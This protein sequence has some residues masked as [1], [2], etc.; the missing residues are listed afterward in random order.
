[1]SDSLR[2]RTRRRLLSIGLALVCLGALLGPAAA[3]GTTRSCGGVKTAGAWTSIDTPTTVNAFAVE[4]SDRARLFVSDG[5]TVY[6][7]VDSGCSWRP[8]FTLPAIPTIEIPFTNERIVAISAPSASLVYLAVTGPHVVVSR[9]GGRTWAA[10]DSGLAL[11]GDPVE[12]IAPAP[13]AVYLLVQ[14]TASD[15]ILDNPFTG[16][17]TGA[18][19]AASVLY[20]SGD[21]GRT[22][23]PSARPS[24]SAQG[25]RGT[26]ASWSEGIGKVWDI[27]VA[28]G[29]PE[30]LWAATVAGV[31]TSADRGAT[32]T[33]A[34]P[35]TGAL[36][37]LDVRAVDAPAAGSVEVVAVDPLAGTV[38]ST[39]SATGAGAWTATSWPG[40]RTNF[41]QV[42]QYK[43]V[44]L[45]HTDG[46]A[47][48]GSGAKGVFALTPPTAWTDVSPLALGSTAGILVDLTPGPDET[49][50]GRA[51]GL[52]ATLLRYSV[53]SARRTTPDDDRSPLAG[54]L[55][56]LAQPSQSIGAL[57]PPRRARLEPGDAIVRLAPGESVTKSYSLALPP[58]PSPVD[59][60]F[61]LDT[62]SS[63]RDVIRALA[64]SVASIATRLR[65]DGVD[66][67]TG[68]GEFRT[69]PYP[70]EAAYNF[71]YRRDVAL[72]PPG[73]ELARALLEIE[74]EGQSGSNLTGL[75]QAATGAGQDV[76]P[77]GRSEGDIAPGQDA[78]FRPHA[79]RVVVHAAD[80]AFA[81]PERGDGVNGKYP[82]PTWPGPGFDEAIAALT[83]NH[84]HQV[85]AAIGY[86]SGARPTDKLDNAWTDLE[87]VAA[88][89][90]TSAPRDGVDCDGDGRIDLR[91][92]RPLVC[93]IPAGHAELLAPAIVGLVEG[94]RDV[95]PVRL[96]APGGAGVVDSIVPAEYPAV[97]LRTR[98]A[99]S[100]DVTYSCPHVYERRTS[101]VRLS[102]LVRTDEVAVA[103]ARVICAR[104]RVPPPAHPHHA[105]PQTLVPPVVPLVEPPPPPVGPGPAAA[106]APQ[107]QPQPNPNPNPQAQ[108]RVAAVA[109]RQAQPQVAL[110]QVAQQMRQELGM[111]H[112]M[113]RLTPRHDPLAEARY[114]LGAGALTVV[115]LY[116]YASLALRTVRRRARL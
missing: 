95:A 11:R 99:L 93:P 29:D 87:R 24:T 64:R 80:S 1:M 110:V 96:V 106:P 14:T 85:G 33:A 71:P 89:T 105:D 63:M 21:A 58:R 109:Q 88:G 36:G 107:V 55:A 38:Y 103:S 76:L 39:S 113:T 5:R 41:A 26:N 43:A 45:A 4:R 15:S 94:V 3:S 62:T 65:S 112:A 28:P 69:Y 78:G 34:L 17:S 79:L 51:G 97:D 48:L 50:Y 22:W 116:G 2:L 46:G 8:V 68:L 23:T 92:G 75:L 18:T 70:G 56:A 81:S 101:D 74:G 7:S 10:S 47:V 20:R 53:R 13:E 42:P 30:R 37:G 104:D 40:F 35:R 57:R 90:G 100:F 67:W 108:P 82:P 60:F 32:W 49:V 6:V 9:D 86:E 12:I 115:M 19:V 16:G 61:L 25:P 114:L 83:K 77:P 102:A 98:H 91:A 111:E 31:F 72:A 84:V 54:P 59:V 27:A 66:V 52:G 44:W 73:P